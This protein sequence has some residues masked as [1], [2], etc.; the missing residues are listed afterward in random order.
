MSKLKSNYSIS[1]SAEHRADSLIVLESRG[2]A[3]A[4]KNARNPDYSKQLSKILRVLQENQCII[5][6]IEVLSTT[7]FRT[8]TARK[9]KLDFPIHVSQVAS[10]EKLRQRIQGAQRTV[11]QRPGASGGNTTKRIG[12]WVRSGPSVPSLGL[13]TL[14]S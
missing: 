5:T 9:L 12:I 10:I 11:S 2:G 13:K 6:R 4:G 8:K 7:A 1:P 14:I 3:K